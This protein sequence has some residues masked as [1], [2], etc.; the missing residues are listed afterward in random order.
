M[1][2]TLPVAIVLAAAAFVW[3][4]AMA[5]AP[6]TAPAA[7]AGGSVTMQWRQPVPAQPDVKGRSI[8]GRVVKPDSAKPSW[9]CRGYLAGQSTPAAPPAEL[10]AAGKRLQQ[11]MAD[12]KI[13]PQLKQEWLAQWSGTPEGQAY[14]TALNAYEQST[15]QTSQPLMLSIAADGSFRADDVQPGNYLLIIY[16][17]QT[18]EAGG[19]A[20]IY[21]MIQRQITVSGRGDDPMD[22][23]QLKLALSNPPAGV[24]KA[25]VISLDAKTLDG[26]TFKLADHRGAYVLVDLWATWTP[27]SDT[28][29]SALND[30]FAAFGQDKKFVMIGL[31]AG[32]SVQD[33]THFAQQHAMPWMQARLDEPAAQ[34]IAEMLGVNSLPAVVLIGPDGKVMAAGLRG[35]GIKA[36]VQE[37][38]NAP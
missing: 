10:L 9:E 24:A 19:S 14:Q 6:T 35:P 34:S 32:D 25:P 16:Q 5:D 7:S 4:A 18:P 23:G 30:V 17:I 31:G 37:A 12:P 22:L 11:T 21:A 20:Q 28:R 13:S 36:V 15:N 1:I 8:I 26:K 33:V 38:L 3:R 29:M 2:K 27:L